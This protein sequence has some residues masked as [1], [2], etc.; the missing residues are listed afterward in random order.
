MGQNGH[1]L[2]YGVVSDVN[3]S[4]V[5]DRYEQAERRWNEVPRCPSEGDVPSLGFVVAESGSGSR[6]DTVP[7]LDPCA[8][9]EIATKY[10]EAI[11]RARERWDRF[12]TFCSTNGMSLPQAKLYLTVTWTA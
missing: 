4:D 8:I 2:M 10:G 1:A 3:L 7:Y 9:D 12:A 5:R 11:L 6:D